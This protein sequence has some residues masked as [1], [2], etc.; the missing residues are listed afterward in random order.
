MQ[1]RKPVYNRSVS[2]LPKPTMARPS[3]RITTLDEFERHII[4]YSKGWY[5]KTNHLD[6][7]R[8]IIA[9]VSGS[10]LQYIYPSDVYNQLVEIATKYVGQFQ[11]QECFKD[12]FKYK[13]DNTITMEEIC[14][15]LLG[16]ISII[17][18]NYNGIVIKLG[19]PDESILPRQREE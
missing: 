5:K 19:E 15:R 4:L 12:F 13:R 1:D 3:D 17:P 16:K 2:K 6:D 11:L 18:V 14:E 9:E 7:I 8:Q 10:E